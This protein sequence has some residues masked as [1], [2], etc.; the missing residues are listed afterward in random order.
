MEATKMTQEEYALANDYN[1]N[2][3]FLNSVLQK[4]SKLDI[5]LKGL[6]DI[7]KDCKQSAGDTESQRQEVDVNINHELDI[8]RKELYTKLNSMLDKLKQH[9]INQQADALKLQ[10]EITAQHQRQQQLR[11]MASPS[12][13][14]ANSSFT[15]SSSSK[16]G[17]SRL[18]NTTRTASPFSQKNSRNIRSQTQS[19]QSQTR[20]RTNSNSSK[21]PT[22]SKESVKPISYL[23]VN[24]QSEEEIQ[25]DKDRK[26][27]GEK[28]SLFNL[29][30]NN[31]KNQRSVLMTYLSGIGGYGWKLE[32]REDFVGRNGLNLDKKEDDENLNSSQDS[33]SLDNINVTSSSTNTMTN[34]NRNN[35]S[36]SHSHSS[37]SHINTMN[38]SNSTQ[39]KDGN[40]SSVKHTNK[41]IKIYSDFKTTN[42]THMKHYISWI[43]KEYST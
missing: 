32:N 34:T 19:T 8:I 40:S 30:W 42:R 36:H 20:L 3:A 14:T 9:Q 13:F 29:Y 37:H 38:S 35:H 26:D 31:K 17:T 22:S 18:T 16:K 11:R 33:M 23:I 25:N 12:P 41:R 4:L 28:G 5:E 27:N 39:Q 21:Q 15:N 43:P 7:F 2:S 24:K 1:T 6:Q 10:Q